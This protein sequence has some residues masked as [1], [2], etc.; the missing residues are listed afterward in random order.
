MNFADYFDTYFRFQTFTDSAM[1]D[2]ITPAGR[3]APNI[4]SFDSQ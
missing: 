4:D 1:C 2:G 3:S